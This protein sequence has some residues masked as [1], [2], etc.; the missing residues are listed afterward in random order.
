MLATE[1][2]S[3]IIEM[4]SQ[5][6]VVA[7][8]TLAR[9]LDVS[10][11]TIRRD[12]TKL[13]QDGIV[14]RCHGGAIVKKEVSYFEKKELHKEDKIKIA[15]KAIDL[16][17][18]GDTVFLDAG[19]TTFEIAKFLNTK[20]E[21]TAITNDLE[22]AYYLNQT[23][24]ET[25]ICGGLIQKETGSTIGVFVDM[26]MQNIHANIAFLGAQSIDAD[27]NVLTPTIEKAVLKKMICDNSNC[28][29]LVADSSKFNHQAL[30]KINHLTDYDGIITNKEFDSAEQAKIHRLG[31]CVISV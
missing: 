19:T 27:F 24:V 17:E 13:K 28:C 25:M 14:E 11:M 30:M 26:M 1:R 8:E 16:V 18:D 31:I 22:I 3:K 21:I 20:K 5:S 2:Y 15:R 6:G 9:K 29:Y 7:V 10:S 23:N 4:V 12:L